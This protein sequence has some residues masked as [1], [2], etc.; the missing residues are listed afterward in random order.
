MG[1][2]CCCLR[3][4]VDTA[5]VNEKKQESARQRIRLS[6]FPLSSLL[7]RPSNS[8]SFNSTSLTP[9]P[10]LFVHLVLCVSNS[11]SLSSVKGPGVVVSAPNTV[12]GTGCVLGNSQLLQNRTYWEVHIL[13]LPPSSSFCV[14]VTANSK[15]ELASPLTSRPSSFAL[16]STH[17]SILS[18]QPGDV[19]GL[20]YDLSGVKTLLGFSINGRREDA[21]TVSGVKGDV[22]P[23]ISV[24]GGA[25]VK[26]V[27]DQASFK[28]GDT[29]KGTSFEAPIRV[30]SVM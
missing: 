3:S 20:Y 23:A 16:S 29:L 9:L 11:V 26:A 12:V 25:S 5:A 1:A 15:D 27:F 6:H 24:D 21:F 28:Y 19:I 18:L 7:F 14:G 22:Y 4:K 13:S 10:S 17:P 30:R 2:L 8:L